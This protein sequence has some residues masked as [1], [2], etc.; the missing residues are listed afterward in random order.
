MAEVYLLGK[1]IY[2]LL[3]EKLSGT[4]QANQEIEWRMWKMVREP[5]RP[6]ITQVSAWKEENKELAIKELRE[7]KRV[8]KRQAELA[9]ELISILF[10]PT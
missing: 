1:S 5:V 4:S 9:N 6:I 7:R 8:R 10:A 2:A 3:I